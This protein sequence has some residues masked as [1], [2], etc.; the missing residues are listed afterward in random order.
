MGASNVLSH[1]CATS[2]RRGHTGT[3]T[4]GTAV[5]RHIHRCRIGRPLPPHSKPDVAAVTAPKQKLTSIPA[6]QPGCGAP[7]RNRTADP[8]LTMEPPGTAVRD[9]VSAGRTPT[10][11]AEVI[12]SLL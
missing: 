5:H 11:R 8:I 7:Q 12:G 9:P 6:G 1:R 10:E 2:P 3:E 4:H